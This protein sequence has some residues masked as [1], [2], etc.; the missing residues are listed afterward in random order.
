[1]STS[2]PEPS[3]EAGLR[4]LNQFVARA[5]IS[6][7]KSRNFDFGPERRGNVSML[8]PYIRHRT[9]LESEVLQATLQQHSIAAADKFVQEVF[10]RAYFKGWLEHHPSV[11]AEYQRWVSQS[12]SDIENDASAWQR[13]ESAVNGA[14]GI[15]CFDA[16]A[17]ELVKYGYL[18]N[19]ARMW[20]ASIWVFTLK[21]PWQL[22]ADFFYR[23]LV[24]GD[25]ASNTLSWRWVCGLHT[26]GKTYLA[27]ASNIAKFTDNR[28]CPDGQLATHASTLTESVAHPVEPLRTPQTLEGDEPFGLLITE[29]D[30]FPENLLQDQE[31]VAVIG[32]TATERRS[33]L[34]IG[35]PAL[36][37][38]T[39]AVSDGVKHTAMRFGVS[40]EVSAGD[41]WG[42]ILAKWAHQHRVKTIVTAY[43]PIG[44][45][46]DVLEEA[47]ETLA[48]HGVK[49]LQLHRAYDTVAW[50]HASRGYFKLREHIPEILARI[51]IPA[52][53][54]TPES[55]S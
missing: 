31:P 37:F 46:F 44:P 52:N 47:N 3:R 14:T 26:K 19:H 27:R 6:Y 36:D 42:P 24:D 30:C 18:H 12:L 10:W 28:F 33:P 9:I 23:H 43:A 7:S 29:D 40:G 21:L 34:P 49:I 48:G 41:V 53:S 51:G 38:A 15:D 50:P 55:R 39:G 1:M 4:Q 54:A 13:Y 22:G 25:P 17:K 45:V 8:S 16:W 20:F 2:T 11:W 35:K 32:L 5:G